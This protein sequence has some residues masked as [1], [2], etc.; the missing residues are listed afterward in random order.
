MQ[1]KQTRNTTLL[2]HKSVLYGQK[3]IFDSKLDKI[4]NLYPSLSKVS[5]IKLA[6]LIH[7]QSFESL[8]AVWKSPH[9]HLNPSS[10]SS[11]DCCI[12]IKLNCYSSVQCKCL[13]F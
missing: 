4:R 2:A 12:S 13:K 6:L 9:H 11:K 7:C 1:Y 3:T 5:W 10:C 8:S